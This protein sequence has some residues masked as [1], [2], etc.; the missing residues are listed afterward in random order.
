MDARWR[1]KA[2]DK[3]L[4]AY[5]NGERF[6][7]LLLWRLTERQVVRCRFRQPPNTEIDELSTYEIC[8]TL[9]EAAALG[10]LKVNFYAEDPILRDDIGEILE[11]CRKLGIYTE[12]T[13][14]GPLMEEKAPALLYAG[15][16]NIP[17]LGRRDVHNRV[18]VG[19]NI[20]EQAVSGVN[21]LSKRG[22]PM[23]FH[24]T[25]T[26]ANEQDSDLEF[27]LQL[28]SKVRARVALEM[29]P[30]RSTGFLIA[31]RYMPAPEHVGRMTDLLLAI[32]TKR[33]SMIQ[34]SR[35]G[36]EH[37]STWPQLP[38][39]QSL[40]GYLYAAIDAE[41]N[42]A[43]SHL[44]AQDSELMSLREMSFRKAFDGLGAHGHD[45]S[46]HMDAVELELMCE[47]G[48]KRAKEAGEKFFG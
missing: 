30:T 20:Y 15:R 35:A 26:N 36:L 4:G 6:P 28:A 25:L 46:E 23:T 16:V 34:N 32:Y 12:V 48:G 42:V 33:G 27:V 2:I 24:F 47:D 14:W 18:I 8:E 5:R 9:E 38:D 41:G 1:K 31:E 10:T 37:L 7:A 22:V 17:I 40:A 43:A 44:R 45:S 19:K 39:R 29:L 21:E 13:A 3:V 11:R